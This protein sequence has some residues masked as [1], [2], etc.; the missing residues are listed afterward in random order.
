MSL[1]SFIWYLLGIDIQGLLSLRATAS[2]IGVLESEIFL[3]P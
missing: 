3:K 1:T 2:K